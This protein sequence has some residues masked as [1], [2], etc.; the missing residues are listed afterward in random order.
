[1]EK[2][3]F[4]KVGELNA[5]KVANVLARLYFEEHPEVEKL[6]MRNPPK[7]TDGET[8]RVDKQ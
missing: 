4:T 7:K 5:E 1:M 2:G 3:T 8:D 6:I